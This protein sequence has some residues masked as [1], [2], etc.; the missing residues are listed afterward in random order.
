MAHLDDPPCGVA[1]QHVRSCRS[2]ERA[3]Q[4]RGFE[5]RGGG[6]IGEIPRRPQGRDHDSACTCPGADDEP[7]AEGVFGISFVRQ[8]LA[9]R[10][11]PQGFRRQRGPVHGR[12]VGSHPRRPAAPDELD[13]HS[14]ALLQGFRGRKSRAYH[15]PARVLRVLYQRDVRTYTLLAIWR[16]RQPHRAHVAVACGLEAGEAQAL[17]VVHRPRPRI[18]VLDRQLA[19]GHV[20][21]PCGPLLVLDRNLARSRMR[22]LCRMLHLEPHP[23]PSTRLEGM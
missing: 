7:Q 14:A 8:E 18:R 19:R 6:R 4:D 17:F 10:H 5:R 11:G 22:L 20:A 16:R 2:I 3:L 13:H 1:R 23:H 21:F 9:L 15:L 12:A